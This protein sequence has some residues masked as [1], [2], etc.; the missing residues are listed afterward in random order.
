VVAANHL[1]YSV[2]GSGNATIDGYVN[3]GTTP[4]LVIHLQHVASLSASDFIL[5]GHAAV[6]LKGCLLSVRNVG[7]TTTRR[8]FFLLQCMSP[9]MA[10]RVIRCA[11]IVRSLLEP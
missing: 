3:N 11:A 10:R 5:F 2:D 9:V 6:T 4:D 1:R 8:S 7:E